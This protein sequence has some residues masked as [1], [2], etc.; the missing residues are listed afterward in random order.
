MAKSLPPQPS[1]EYLKKQAKALLKA[2][3]QS[4]PEVISRIREYHPRLSGAPDS[5][6]FSRAFSL[7][8]AQLVIAREYGC[9]SWPRLSATISQL[10]EHLMSAQ[11]TFEDVVQLTDRETQILLRETETQDVILGLKDA[12]TPLKEKFLTNMSTRTR[13][14]FEDRI[15]ALVDRDQREIEE[16]RQRI[17]D[18]LGKSVAEGSIIWPREEK[19]PETKPKAKREINKARQERGRRLKMYGQ[20]PQLSS[21]ELTALIVR[22]AEL[23]QGTGILSLESAEPD[24]ADPLVRRAVELIVDG[25]DP[26]L[27]RE[28][29]E[30]L[31]Q[32]L[33][34][35][36]ELMYRMA[37]D[38]LTAVQRG[39]NP[40]LVEERLRAAAQL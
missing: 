32:S 36:Q 25:Y 34:K 12:S 13:A 15:D 14:H 39:E 2:Y 29:L 24:I 6:I 5:D 20:I 21:D 10:K 22:L 26:K 4:N 8:D 40:R 11:L 9:E 33:L 28:T 16:A 1:L 38:G 27:V 18:W 7:Q 17:S 31:M 23:A 37:I 30:E 3:K 35:N 19:K